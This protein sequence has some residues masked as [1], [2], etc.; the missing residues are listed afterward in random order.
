[1]QKDQ[2]DPESE[3][4]PEGPQ[5]P[6]PQ[7]GSEGPEAQEGPEG[8]MIG[9]RSIVVEDD[10]VQETRRFLKIQIY[11]AKDANPEFKKLKV[12]RNYVVKDADPEFKRLKGFRV[13]KGC[14]S[15]LSTVPVYLTFDPEFKK[16][17]LDHLPCKTS[18]PLKRKLSFSMCRE[19][20]LQQVPS[21]SE[22]LQ[23]ASSFVAQDVKEKE[24]KTETKTSWPACDTFKEAA[25]QMAQIHKRLNEHFQNNDI[26]IFNIT[27]KT[28]SSMHIAL[29]A[30]HL[31]PGL[32]WCSGNGC[33]H[34]RKK[35]NLFAPCTSNRPS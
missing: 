13:T 23:Q 31:H 28:Q 5:T 33:S 11:V 1:M 27:S 14:K 29:L 34:I 16:M 25:F 7:E 30:E 21:E 3:E 19:T 24:P 6:N 32:T 15:M 4:G 22:L 17:L 35:Q 8:H 20:H 10:F 12:M 2:T 26:K 18:W 9:S